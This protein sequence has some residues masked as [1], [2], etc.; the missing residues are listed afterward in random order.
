MIVLKNKATGTSIGTLT[1]T[2]LQ[3]LLDHLE[4]EN[5]QDQ[6]YLLNR[7]QLD[8]FWEQGVDA[9]LLETLEKA[10]G[11]AEEMEIVWER[12]N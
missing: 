6:D 3:Y 12:T 1:D 7:T 9:A 2:Q 11:D 5:D 4:E 10:L 8:L